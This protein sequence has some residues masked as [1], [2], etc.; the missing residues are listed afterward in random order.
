M[1]WTPLGNEC[2]SAVCDICKKQ[3]TRKYGTLVEKGWIIGTD[4]ERKR[5]CYCPNHKYILSK[6]ERERL[7][8]R[9]C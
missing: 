8:S 4:W 2:I 9:E 5:P 1:G 7:Q 6:R 3:K